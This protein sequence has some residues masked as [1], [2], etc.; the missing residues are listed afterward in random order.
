[1]N[2]HAG[3]AKSD[4]IKL[5]LDYF[6]IALA[7]NILT[8][9]EKSEIRF[10]KRLFRIRPEEF[11]KYQSL[12][13]EYLINTRLDRIYDDNVVNFHERILKDDLQEIVGL[14][15]DEMNNYVKGWARKSILKGANV[16][17]LDVLFTHEEC[18]EILS[19]RDKG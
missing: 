4:F 17:N 19:K 8:E 13:V 10:L 12:R 6:E 2:I 18:E 5:I 7:D 9:D 16:E 15:Y 11:K 14:S 1:M 3:V